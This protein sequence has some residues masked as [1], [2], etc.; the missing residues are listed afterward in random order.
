MIVDND[1]D[2]GNWEV[3]Y[4]TGLRIECVWEGEGRQ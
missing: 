1:Y 4:E 3:V 2:C